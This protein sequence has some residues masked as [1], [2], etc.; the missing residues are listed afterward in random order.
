MSHEANT[1]DAKK[2]AAWWPEF[3]LRG[4]GL[5][6]EG[7]S[8]LVLAWQFSRGGNHARAMALLITILK[9]LIFVHSISN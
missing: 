9:I 1:L 2:F 4:G 7:K 8:A 6:G 5:R 3:P